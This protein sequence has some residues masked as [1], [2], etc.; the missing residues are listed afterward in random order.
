MGK[1]WNKLVKFTD[2]FIN[3]IFQTNAVNNDTLEFVY[4]KLATGVVVI[5]LHRARDRGTE[6]SERQ[7]VGGRDIWGEER[8]MR[9]W[10]RE[11]T[12]KERQRYIQ[13]K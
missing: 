7:K 13:E 9:A 11:N 12:E 10:W 2:S 5:L 4:N 6:G 3:H 8:R 1:Q